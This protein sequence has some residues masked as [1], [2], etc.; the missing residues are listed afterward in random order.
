MFL[1]ADIVEDIEDKLNNKGSSIKQGLLVVIIPGN[2]DRLIYKAKKLYIKYIKKFEVVVLLGDNYEVCIYDF[3]QKYED[4][5]I[6]RE[7]TN[8]DDRKVLI[9]FNK[10]IR[11]T[12]IYYKSKVLIRNGKVEK[13]FIYGLR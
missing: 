1:F 13:E 6:Y 11:N 9:Q 10:A 5:Q 2:E 8:L 4:V 3:T 7:Y 12:D